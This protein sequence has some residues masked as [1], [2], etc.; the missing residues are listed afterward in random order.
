M[1]SCR[2]NAELHFAK[3]K[4]VKT[5]A[6]Q[7]LSSFMMTQTFEKIFTCDGNCQN[8]KKC[9][10]NTSAASKIQQCLDAKAVFPYWTQRLQE[11]ER[12]LILCA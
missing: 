7:S 6:Y 12:V 11:Q 9:G 10:R 5:K 2:Q 3:P 8:P 4:S 1:Q